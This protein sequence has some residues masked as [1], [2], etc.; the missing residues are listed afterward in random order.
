MIVQS[1]QYQPNFYG[2]PIFIAK[3]LKPPALNQAI[4]GSN[5]TRAANFSHGTVAER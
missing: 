4:V 2:A 1:L 5:P 3:R